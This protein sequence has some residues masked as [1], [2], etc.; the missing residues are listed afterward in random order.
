MPDDREIS[1]R[2]ELLERQAE[3]A[4][5]IATEQRE[6]VNE[7]VAVMRE[8]NVYYKEIYKRTEKGEEHREE[9]D[10]AIKQLSEVQIRNQPAIESVNR[11][12]AGLIGV[13]FTVIAGVSVN[14]LVATK[15]PPVSE[16]EYKSILEKLERLE[17]TELNQR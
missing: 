2:F 13:V 6:D 4:R 7:L 16:H 11:I 5:R 17:T 9:Q 15:E 10:K 3:E 12:K 1:R 14:Y 8:S